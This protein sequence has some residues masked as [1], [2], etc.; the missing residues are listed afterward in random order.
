MWRIS[1][2]YGWTWPVEDGEP[3]PLN[4]SAFFTCDGGL[5]LIKSLNPVTLP[6]GSLVA[7]VDVIF[8]SGIEIHGCLVHVHGQSCWVSPPGKPKLDADRRQ[9]LD[10]RG[11]PDFTQFIFFET[12]GAKARWSS[13][14]LDAIRRQYPDFPPPNS[15]ER[16]QPTMWAGRRP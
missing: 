15:D 6:K 14:I 2:G 5:T 8:P 10:A 4:E 1:P 3:T 13:T 11:K 9:L 12:H 16:E 7:F